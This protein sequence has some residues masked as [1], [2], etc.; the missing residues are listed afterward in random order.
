M[1]WA[2]LDLGTPSKSSA[3]NTKIVDAARWVRLGALVVLVVPAFHG[4]S[5]YSGGYL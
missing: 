4:G 3:S 5:G 2:F 1:C